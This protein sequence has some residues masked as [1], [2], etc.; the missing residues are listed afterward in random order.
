MLLILYLKMS[1]N[2]GQQVYL[3]CYF[4]RIFVVICFNFWTVITELILWKLLSVY[5]TCPMGVQLFQNHLLKELTF[6]FSI[7]FISFLEMTCLYLWESIQY[8]ELLKFCALYSVPLIYLPLYHFVLYWLSYLYSNF[9]M[10]EYHY[11]EIEHSGLLFWT[12]NISETWQSVC[13]YF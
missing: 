2:P 12:F 13:E 10:S 11:S 7:F 5:F 4:S 8:Y 1:I 6:L 9:L 3:L